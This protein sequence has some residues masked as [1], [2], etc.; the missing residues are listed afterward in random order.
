MCTQRVHNIRP[1]GLGMVIVP[2]VCMILLDRCTFVISLVQC[3]CD[4][5]VNVHVCM[6]LC[7][8]VCVY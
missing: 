6:C 1:V 5:F 8:M 4:M 2:H 3:V 7:A